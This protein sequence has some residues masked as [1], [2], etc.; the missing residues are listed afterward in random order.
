MIQ[1][2]I[3]AMGAALMASSLSAQSRS[4]FSSDLNGPQ[5]IIRTQGGRFLVSEAGIRALNQGRVSVVSST[6]MRVTLLGGLP[7]GIDA[8]GDLS[9]PT[10][11]AVEGNILYL[12]SA[13]ATP[14]ATSKARPYLIPAASG[15]PDLQLHLE[16]LFSRPISTI[17]CPR[18]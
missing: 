14:C 16:G 8:Q 9:G 11:L 13:R 4:V 6:G 7:S 15:A 2:A 3:V 1:F 5:K 10:G 18:L 12:A 17:Y